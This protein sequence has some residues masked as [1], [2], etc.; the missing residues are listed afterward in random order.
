MQN[1]ETLDIYQLAK[2]LAIEIQKMTLDELPK[3]GMYEEGSQIRH[4]VTSIVSNIVE[5]FGKK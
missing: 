1:Y 5:S 2:T 3:L 4:S